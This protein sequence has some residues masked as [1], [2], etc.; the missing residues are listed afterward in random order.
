MR[1]V[2]ELAALRPGVRHH[3]VAPVQ[4]FLRRDLGCQFEEIG[5]LGRGVGEF[6]DIRHVPTRDDQNMGG[7]LRVDI[8]EGQRVRAAGDHRGRDSLGDDAAEEAG[9]RAHAA[10]LDPPVGQPGSAVSRLWGVPTLELQRPATG[11]AADG[12]APSALRPTPLRPSVAAARGTADEAIAALYAAHWDSLVRLAWLLLRDQAAAEDVV[13]D[14]FIATHRG[15]DRIRDQGA[16]LGYLRRAVVNGARSVHRHEIVV[17]REL[18]AEGGRADGTGRAQAA[19]A[20]AEAIRRIGDDEMLDALRRLPD[21][22]REVLVLR[23]FA[24]W[25]EAQIAD[26]LGIARGSVKAHAHRGLAALRARMEEPS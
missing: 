15:Y 16:A 7:R 19:S 4:P 18:L 23:Y 2:D 17:R 10:R 21:R 11:A 20:E 1:V 14:A 13:Q 9:G 5:E 6:T 25:S 3:S 24:D 26:A 12:P 8:A 22:Q